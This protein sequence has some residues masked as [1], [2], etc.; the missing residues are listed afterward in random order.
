M[1][2][3]IFQVLHKLFEKCDLKYAIKKTWESNEI[4]R[5]RANA[6]IN[7]RLRNNH[8]RMMTSEEMDIMLARTVVVGQMKPNWFQRNI[9]YYQDQFSRKKRRLY[10][11]V[12]K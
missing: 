11:E 2:K 12:S 7:S 3:K 5:K 9:P 8:S 4:A 6:V 1:I 10:N